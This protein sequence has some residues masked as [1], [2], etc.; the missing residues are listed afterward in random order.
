MPSPDR[1]IVSPRS[2]IRLTNLRGRQMANIL[3]LAMALLLCGDA[4]SQKPTVPDA[5]TD[6]ATSVH[7]ADADCA[8]CHQ[9]IYQ[10]YLTT[11]MANASGFAED[12]LIPTDFVQKSANINYKI[13]LDHGKAQLTY[14]VGKGSDSLKQHSLNYFLGSGHLAITY[15]YSTNGLLFESPIAWY[16]ASKAYD[17]K[18]GL[19]Q[20][21]QPAPSLPMQSSCLRC[22]MSDVQPADS[23]TINRYKN[24]PFLHTGITCEACHGDP[25][26][27]LLHGDK[28]AII[29]PANL[30]PD[31][32]DSICISCHLEG[33]ITVERANHSAL[34]YKAGESI[35][36]YLAFYVY[37][38]SDL[39]TRGVSEVEQFAQSRC[40]SV[41]GDKMS[42]TSCHD[43]H[44]SP[45]AAER[46][47]FYRSKCLA[48]HSSPEFT[49]AHHPENQDCTSC[50]MSSTGAE[51]IPH[52]AWTDH[53][54]L[55]VKQLLSM[56]SLD[57]GTH[58]LTPIFSSAAT[59][60]DLAM[61]NYKAVLEGNP[62]LASVALDQLTQLRSEINND[63]EALDAFATLSARNNDSKSA[64]QAFRRVLEIVPDD[65]TA[66]SN[67][68]ALLAKQGKVSD[69]IAMLQPAF[70]RNPNLSGLAMNLAKI[71]CASADTNAAITTL[72][73][74]LLYNPGQQNV[75]K[76]ESQM[77][78]CGT[79]RDK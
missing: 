40:K 29:N 57:S 67:L 65:L 58:K 7:D 46:T 54:I 62:S 42:C 19:K 51:N 78:N 16:S 36:K 15:L 38:G 44:Y 2:K 32:R 5:K 79:L 60:R 24:L 76:L 4:N 75:E 71:Q 28:T 33:D 52:V 66:L 25:K 63:A 68:G 6:R 17:L 23:G 56:E 22:H 53:R 21:N 8:K 10:R 70:D 39:T 48:C 41:S 64:E 3:W 34:N 47:T 12:K 9:E 1:Q 61:A 13:S 49:A 55:K 43:P 73:T 59:P 35:S 30:D 77:S 26:A 69:A 20:T 11:P 74:T 27:H 72:R 50:H 18:P 31:A 37:R 14:Q 45:S